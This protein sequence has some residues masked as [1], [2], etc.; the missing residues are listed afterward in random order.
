M[1]S[2]TQ[3]GT[4]L[5]LKYRRLFQQSML[6][7]TYRPLAPLSLRAVSIFYVWKAAPLT[8]LPELRVVTIGFYLMR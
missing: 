8:T 5:S 3:T 7:W 1:V 4:S 6:R 2:N